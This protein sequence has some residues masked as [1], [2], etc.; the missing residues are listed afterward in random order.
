MTVG[1]DVWGRPEPFPPLIASTPQGI[2]LSF[3]LAFFGALWPDT[4]IKS[5]SQ[6]LIY[7]LFF[8]LDL[9]LLIEK[10]Y[11]YS[12]LLGLFVMLPLLG[13]HRGWTHSRLTMFLLPAPLL[14]APMYLDQA[15][16]N[17]VGLPYY[18]AA[19]IGYGTHL[20]LDG[21]LIRKHK[22]RI[23]HRTNSK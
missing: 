5:K 22:K 7:R 9:L 13:K 18:L 16:A 6:Q 20:H 4:D 3:A 15:P 12:A 2:A 19:M 21:R 17:L 10:F 14:I 11:F 23:A 1:W 8:L